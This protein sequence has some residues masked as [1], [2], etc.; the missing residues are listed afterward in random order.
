MNID[1]YLRSLIR[2][3]VLEELNKATTTKTEED[4]I[5]VS[6]G[7]KWRKLKHDEIIRTG[8]RYNVFKDS[9]GLNRA[10]KSIGMKVIDAKFEFGKDWEWYRRID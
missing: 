4:Y 7:F 2:E 1:E 8:D 9:N 3:I 5:V 6:F 10:E